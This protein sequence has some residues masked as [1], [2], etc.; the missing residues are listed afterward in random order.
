MKLNLARSRN[1]SLAV[2]SRA[3]ARHVFQKVAGLTI[4]AISVSQVGRRWRSKWAA[5]GEQ[6]AWPALKVA[7]VA[8]VYYPD[9]MDEI[10][11]CQA[12]L[13]AGAPLFVTVSP[14][15]SALVRAAAVGR[16]E[17]FI[18]EHEN[19]GR[20]ISPFLT[21]LS[22]G[23]LDCYD[24]VL[25]LHTKRSPHLLDGEIRRKLLFDKLC[26]NWNTTCRAL[27]AFNEPSTGI[28]GWGQCWRATPSY[29]MANESRVRELAARMQAPDEAVRLG[30][31][32]GT[33]FWFRPAALASLREL[34]LRPAAFEM[35]ARQ[36]DG[37]LHHAVERCFTIAAW[38]R[39][40]DVRD[41]NGRLL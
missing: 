25:K 14:D 20:D 13:P 16:K 6:A 17:V 18:H 19:R 36:L 27:A 2:R 39:G 10:L 26:G 29:W 22:T 32:E 21:L 4:G 3:Y 1:V 28:V 12:L 35:E 33:M 31:F 24:A 23:V 15:R 8:H 40:F 34:N 30:F 7:I 5:R 9:L 37:T 41:L 11:A 38:S